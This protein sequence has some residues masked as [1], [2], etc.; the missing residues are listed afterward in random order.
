MRS[1]KRIRGKGEGRE[2]KKQNVRNS[3]IMDF[4]GKPE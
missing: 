3:L 1:R 2:R 4:R